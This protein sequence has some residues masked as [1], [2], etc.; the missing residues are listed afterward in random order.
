[1]TDVLDSAFRNLDRPRSEA[2]WRELMT[3]LARS[4]AGFMQ[5]EPLDLFIRAEDDKPGA[6]QW[7][8]SAYFRVLL[9]PVPRFEAQILLWMTV[10]VGSFASISGTVLM[11]AD[12]KRIHGPG[13]KPLFHF[14][15]GDEWEA[16]GWIIDEHGEYESAEE[17]PPL[18]SPGNDGDQG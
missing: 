3:A 9:A 7:Y 11:F 18:P 5:R 15:G 8:A 10:D 17:L 4:L 12:G 14:Q 16:Q 13:G 2:E 1:M 6:E